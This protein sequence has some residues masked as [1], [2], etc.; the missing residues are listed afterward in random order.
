L[1]TPSYNRKLCRWPAVLDRSNVEIT[2]S[3]TVRCMSVLNSSD[4]LWW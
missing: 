1:D 3:N 2:G 4:I